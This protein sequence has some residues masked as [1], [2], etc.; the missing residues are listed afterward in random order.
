VAEILRKG[1]VEFTVSCYSHG[2]MDGEK[3]GVLGFELAGVI[4]IVFYFPSRI[5]ERCG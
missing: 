4:V 1:F 3:L 2:L 5:T